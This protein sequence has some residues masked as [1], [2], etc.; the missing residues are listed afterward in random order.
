M[1]Q[2]AKL[3]HSTDSAQCFTVMHY[4][5]S[6]STAV[7]SI[8]RVFMMVRAN[9]P[10]AISCEVSRCRYES[11]GLVRRLYNIIAAIFHQR[12]LN[13][14]TGDV[15]YLTLLLRKSRTILTVHDCGGMHRLVGLKRKIYRFFW[16]ILP[17]WRSA[18]V[19]AVSD[20]SKAELV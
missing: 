13:H 16:L 17:I 5:R 12:D 8:E 9:M 19:V 18:A 10:P 11:R 4:Q 15:H 3:G 1:R 6:A 20:F 2:L 7:F 14:I